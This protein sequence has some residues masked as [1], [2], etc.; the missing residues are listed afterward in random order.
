VKV[1][2]KSK[3]V[4][5]VQRKV[6]GHLGERIGT[7]T[8]KIRF[9]EMSQH[10]EVVVAD[11]FTFQ[12]VIDSV[13]NKEH[14]AFPLLPE[15]VLDCI[16][17]GVWLDCFPLVLHTHFRSVSLHFCVTRYGATLS[18]RPLLANSPE[19]LVIRCILSHS[20]LPLFSLLGLCSGDEQSRFSVSYG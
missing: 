1:A 10:T 12:N 17:V 18:L 13:T 14:P 6:T 2:E 19:L 7:T 16:E 5:L 15:C 9:P 20:V 3:D 8:I 11:F 4:V